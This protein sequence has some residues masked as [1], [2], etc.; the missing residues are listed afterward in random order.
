MLIIN[1]WL[2]AAV[3]PNQFK[4]RFYITGS[5]YFICCPRSSRRATTRLKLPFK[6]RGNRRLRKPRLSV[7]PIRVYKYK[8][9]DHG[10]LFLIEWLFEKPR[11]FWWVGT[12]VRGSERGQVR[13]IRQHVLTSWGCDLMTHTRHAVIIIPSHWTRLHGTHCNTRS[14]SSPYG[15]RWIT[16]DFVLTLCGTICTRPRIRISHRNE[17]YKNSARKKKPIAPWNKSN[18]K[19]PNRPFQW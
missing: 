6:S 5:C 10:K 7:R 8:P 12:R 13:A 3:L 14:L 15:T 17:V 1:G 4:V 11:V 18:C 16:F 9:P 2:I 19:S